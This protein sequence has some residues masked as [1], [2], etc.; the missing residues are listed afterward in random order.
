M[1]RV[2]ICAILAA[3]LVVEPAVARPAACSSYDGAELYARDGKFLGSLADRYSSNSIFNKYGNY[4]SKYS[5]TS[6]W[7][8]YGTYGGEYSNY[9]P[10]NRYSNDGPRIVKNR[11]VIAVLT[12]N[13]YA[14]GAVNPWTLA[15]SCYGFQPD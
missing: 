4:G 7:N 2:K 14:A 1:R 9:S 10:F 15:V 6:I 5:S 8:R 13:K 11:R 12:A 3:T